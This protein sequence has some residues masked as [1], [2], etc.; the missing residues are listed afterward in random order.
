MRGALL[1]V[2]LLPP[3]PP[4]E[5]AKRGTWKGWFWPRD[6]G[7]RGWVTVPLWAQGLGTPALGD[8]CGVTQAACVPR[9][10]PPALAAPSLGFCRGKGSP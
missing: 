5:A 2:Q 9:G 10:A 7:E 3:G 4:S 6:G 1:G 8:P